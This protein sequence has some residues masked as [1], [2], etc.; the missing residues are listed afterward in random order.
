MPD[1]P[2]TTATPLMSAAR[3][4]SITTSGLVKSI[5]A[6]GLL[7]ASASPMASSIN[8]PSGPTP[9]TRPISRRAPRRAIAATSSRSGSRMITG[10]S[11]R[12]TQPVAPARA[13]RRR[14]ILGSLLWTS[15]NIALNPLKHFL[16]HLKALAWAGIDRMARAGHA[17]E[18]H[19]RVPQFLQPDI[20]LLA[21]LYR[22]AIVIFSMNDARRRCDVRRIGERRTLAVDRLSLPGQTIL[23]LSIG[24]VNITR[25]KRTGQIAHTIECHSRLKPI[26]MADN[27]VGHIPAI[28]ATCHRHPRRVNPSA[29]NRSIHTSQNILIILA[30]PIK[31][32]RLR[33]R[34]ARTTTPARIDIQRCIASRRQHLRPQIECA[35][36]RTERPA[37][38]PEN[39]WVLRARLRGMGPIQPAI[40]LPI[41]RPGE[42]ELLWLHEINCAQQ[43]RIHRRQLALRSLAWQAIQAILIQI[44]HIARIG[45]HGEKVMPIRRQS[46]H[47]DM[48][49]ACCNALRRATSRREAKYIRAAMFN[50]H[51]VKPGSISGPLGRR[52]ATPIQIGKYPRMTIQIN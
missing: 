48:L 28:A 18:L 7:C 39:Q 19:W 35:A 49:R 16:A 37:M 14:V 4:W 42:G 30:A 43:R 12:P 20:Q 17:N 21:L 41:I 46:D 51:R 50:N 23:P 22:A 9:T 2:T 29:R 25:P 1:V 44:P 40:D 24:G 8:T 10:T 26:R 15:R 27:P 34:L 13:T 11:A 32:N 47:T 33:K 31:I 3:T 6:C 52:R 36:I 38:N 5:S 45:P